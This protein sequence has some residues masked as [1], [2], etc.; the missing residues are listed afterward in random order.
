MTDQRS[1][2]KRP[3]TARK[4]EPLEQASDA[5]YLQ[6]LV[7]QIP[8]FLWVIDRDLIVRRIEGG[9]PMLE[10]LDRDRL[11]GLPMAEVTRMG[12]DAKDLELSIDMHRRV[13]QG[14]S[15]QYRATWKGIT[16]ESRVRPLRDREGAVVGI[17]G[18]GIDVTDR[19]RMEAQLRESEERFR[20]VV[21]G[22][23]DLIAILD[24]DCRMTYVSPSH[25][26]VLGYRTSEARSVDPWSLVHPDD[27]AYAREQFAALDRRRSVRFSRPIRIRTRRGGWRQVVVVLTDL[28]RAEAVRGIVVNARD[29]TKELRLES[30][31]RQ[32]QKL[33][34]LGQLAGGVAHD[35]NN[36]LAAISGYAHLVHDDLAE[37]DPGRRDLEEILKAAE[38][39]ANITR[40]LLA[41]SRQ[42]MPMPER[43]DLIEVVHEI[44][45][46]L[47]ALLPATIALG[48]SP[49]RGGPAVDVL[50]DR[51]QL[52]LVITN[53]V[54]NARDAMPTGGT[55]SVDVRTG[56]TPATAP[57]AVLEVRDS[58]IGM[59]PEVQAQVF[60]PFFTTKELGRGTGLGLATVHAIVHQHAG[61]IDLTSAVGKGTT[62]TVRLPLAV[63]G[64]PAVVRRNE[65]VEPDH[66]GRVL[67]IED[68][69]QV[70]EV[71]TRF[72]QRAGYD[73][74][75]A[76]DAATA[77]DLLGSAAGF[78]VVLTDS[79]MPGMSGEDFA[80][81]IV[82]VRP[83][84]PVILMS[85]Y[86][87]PAWGPMSPAVSAF[88]QKP[89][90]MPGLLAEVRRVM[91]RARSSSER[92]P[93]SS[94]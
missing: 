75:A 24:D 31:L 19:T 71:A 48:V 87:D 74:V 67:V 81:A 5:E 56:A 58:G 85:G 92:R 86:R 44:S 53:L 40:Q 68:Q 16:L 30:R 77:L 8:A 88:V 28:R 10:A 61:S 94:D 65:R 76:S 72:L 47:R 60:E 37:D 62:V 50:A 25:A 1:R 38:R 82:Q 35:F 84:L 93:S 20:A 59:A 80:K 73:V 54:V 7:D 51:N 43:L 42:Q 45:G 2:P 14:E 89:F 41:F 64:A 83:G 39:A 78:D 79:A 9:R 23:A 18:V 91:V 27:L 90:T 29:V 66:A 70:R 13:L 3:S 11:I 12:T 52:E 69:I 55:L 17:L 49:G 4:R 33:E 34:A 21:E 36:V 46:M 63:A 26:R 6:Q 32:S 22:S 15:G 57:T